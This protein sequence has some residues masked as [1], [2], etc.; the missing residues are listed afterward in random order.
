MAQKTEER[1]SELER[2]MKDLIYVHMK[3]EVT[4]NDFIEESKIFQGEM[5]GFKDEMKEFKDEMRLEV[6]KMNKKWG[7]L[8]NKMG[9]V[10]DDIVAPNIPRIAKEYFNCSNL[11]DFI[12][13]WR[14]RNKKDKARVKEFD[15]IAKCENF[16]I[17][18]E[19]K[20]TVKIEYVNDFIKTLS[21][22]FD[23]FPEYKSLKIIPIFSSFSIQKDIVNYLTREKIYAMA[24]KGEDM[25]LLNPQLKVL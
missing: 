15:V 1:V 19:T 22:I 6:K 13:R 8:A 21:E 3:T 4:L 11:D 25:D 18:N 5:K 20:S 24:M 16:V 23:Y 17:I 12:I 10:A 2:M 9:T 14:V 7:D